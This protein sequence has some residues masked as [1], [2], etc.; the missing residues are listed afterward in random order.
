MKVGIVGAGAV[1]SACAVAL[2]HRGVAREIVLVDRDRARAAA[3]ATD[4]RYGAALLPRVDIRD[5]GFADLGGSG[6]VM[7]TAG[8]NEKTGGAADRDDPQG[9]LRLLHANADVFEEVVPAVD[10]AAPGTVVLVVTDPPDPL[11]DLARRLAGHD[12]VL[13][14]GTLIDTLRLRVEI[15]R[16]LGVGPDVVEALVVG[17]HGVSEVMLWSSARVGGAPVADVCA[18][19][20][21]PFDGFRSHVEKAVRYANVAII[22]GNGASQHGIGIVCARLAQV[23]LR[24]ERAVLPVGTYQEPYGV[25]MSLPSVIGRHGVA[26]VL[27]PAM[28]DAERRQL[29]FSAARLRSALAEL[30][31]PRGAE[32]KGAA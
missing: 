3:V 17:E 12:R 31:A 28:S 4:I 15:A 8:I 20:G 25:T 22:E 10:S 18:E 32:W 21:V 13:S 29:E 14:T 11:A 19:R 23:I 5:G 24:D 6:L 2:A 1:G 7:I 27:E 26:S 16:R 9:R 30:R